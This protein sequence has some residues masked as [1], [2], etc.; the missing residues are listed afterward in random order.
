MP[1]PMTDWGSV[2]ADRGN[3]AR[4]QPGGYVA[5]IVQ[6]SDVSDETGDYLLV[7]FDIAEGP[8]TGYYQRLFQQFPGNWNGKFRL[9]YKSPK[10]GE[11]LGRLKAFME[12]LNISNG[13]TIHQFDA[14]TLDALAKEGKIFGVLMG[15]DKRVHKYLNVYQT[16][17]AEK[18][19]SGEYEIPD[20]WKNH[21]EGKRNSG[22]YSNSPSSAGTSFNNL[23]DDDE[24]LPFD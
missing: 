2:Q 11:T 20:E 7:E 4:L 15:Y 13:I 6:L 8:F 12:D 24:D 23:P 10:H 22:G 19:R 17:D 21:D 5:K 9:Y 14:H 1:I 16:C 3:F 18:V